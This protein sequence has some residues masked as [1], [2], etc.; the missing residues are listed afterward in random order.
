L[1]PSNL[2]DLNRS[3]S[4]NAKPKNADNYTTFV[5]ILNFYPSTIS[6][7]NKPELEKGVKIKNKRSN[8]TTNYWENS[9]SLNLYNQISPKPTFRSYQLKNK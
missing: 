7:V 3:L 4:L 2:L 5:L 6:Y 8:F 1:N 9:C